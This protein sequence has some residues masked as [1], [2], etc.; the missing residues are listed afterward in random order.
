ML[1]SNFM[2]HSQPYSH[3]MEL[4][5]LDIIQNVL[6]PLSCLWLDLNASKICSLWLKEPK[7]F[8]I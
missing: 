1:Q 3:E 2:M 4:S 7:F 6:S 8:K 5:A